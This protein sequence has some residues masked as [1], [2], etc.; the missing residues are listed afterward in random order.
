MIFHKR[1]DTAIYYLISFVTTRNY[2]TNKKKELP[3]CVGW[4]S[5]WQEIS[6]T[7]TELAETHSPHVDDDLCCRISTNII[8]YD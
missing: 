6:C 5:E 7:T 1:S 2:E 3:N 8:V 4:T